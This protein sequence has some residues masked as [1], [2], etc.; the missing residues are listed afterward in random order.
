MLEGKF[1][2]AADFGAR[3]VGHSVKSIA[4]MAM[5][6][7]MTVGAA[8]AANASDCPSRN[9]SSALF[10]RSL[11]TELM[12]AALSCK[13]R[14]DYN[15]F[16]VQFRDTLVQNGKQMKAYFSRRYG[17]SGRYELDRFITALANEASAIGMNSGPGYCDDARALFK[18]V[19]S[20]QSADLE[21]FSLVNAEAVLQTSVVC[22]TQFTGVSAGK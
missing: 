13:A 1:G 11:Q 2:G 19:L 17:G 12:V 10:V 20:L 3:A 6:A 16:A 21:A 4:A 15:A 5:A 8:T 22:E 18:E 7:V 9:E 14:E